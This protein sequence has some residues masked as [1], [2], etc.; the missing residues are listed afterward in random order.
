MRFTTVGLK[1]RVTELE[2]GDV[3]LLE[4]DDQSELEYRQL[5]KTPNNEVLVVNLNKS[6]VSD[7]YLSLDG[8][9]H[10]YRNLKNC[11]VFLADED[12]TH[13]ELSRFHPI[14]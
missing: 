12:G 9:L 7:Q 14:N 4:W 6:C 11:R 1:P 3:L 2:F 10:F 8:V 5:F 13:L